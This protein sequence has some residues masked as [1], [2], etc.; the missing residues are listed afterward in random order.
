M[1]EMFTCHYNKYINKTTTLKQ[2]EQVLK[3]E[4]K[5]LHIF[6]SNYRCLHTGVPY[7]TGWNKPHVK[8]QCSLF[9]YICTCPDVIL[10]QTCEY[11]PI[12]SFTYFTF[13]TLCTL[14]KYSCFKLILSFTH[15]CYF[16]N[17]SYKMI[18]SFVFTKMSMLIVR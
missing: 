12:Q 4:L 5:A 6:T 16:L 7:N 8:A 18:Q 11:N 17:K 2:G 13:Y 1:H 9:T 3:P 10:I 14:Y 15:T